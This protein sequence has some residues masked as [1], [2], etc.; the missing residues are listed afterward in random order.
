LPLIVILGN[1]EGTGAY[2]LWLIGLVI[3]VL[4]CVLLH[5]LGHALSARRYG[6]ETKD[7]ILSG[8]G[9][10]ARLKNMPKQPIQELIIAVAGPAVNVVIA[11]ILAIFLLLINQFHFSSGS[12]FT[13]T[14]FLF[15]LFIINIGLIV[16]N[17]IPAF[18]MDGGRVL[19]A[20][21]SM[22]LDKVKA[23]KIAVYIAYFIAFI[24]LFIPYWFNNYMLIIISIFIVISA[25][26]ELRSIKSQAFMTNHTVADAMRQQFT[27][28]EQ[29][30]VM[31]YAVQTLKGSGQKHFVVLNLMQVVGVLTH[32]NIIQSIKEKRTLTP[33]SN[34]MNRNFSIVSPKDSIEK[35]YHLFRENNYEIIPVMENN[36]IIGVLDKVGMNEF[37]EIAA[38]KK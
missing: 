7:I 10:I 16:F 25:T 15:G 4:I 19:R 8:I 26:A 34:Y 35:A 23:T 27:V 37:F 20:I 14:D 28:L 36:V 22:K 13:V 29:S 30:N 24:F 32:H 17:L 18:P 9:G 33:V 12:T 3:C 31:D 2:N 5:E 1:K 11:A 38:A 21:L 6:V